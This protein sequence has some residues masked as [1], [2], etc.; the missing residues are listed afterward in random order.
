[1]TSR[2]DVL[3][4]LLTGA[5]AIAVPATTYTGTLQQY[6]TWISYGDGW[7]EEAVSRLKEGFLPKFGYIHKVDVIVKPRAYLENNDPLNYT[8]TAGVKVLGILKEDVPIFM[9]MLK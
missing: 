9:P 4:S 7:E 8:N 1:M 3:K 6:G 2:R 5:V